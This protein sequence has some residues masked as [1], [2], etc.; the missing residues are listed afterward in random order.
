MSESITC[1]YDVVVV[2]AGNAALTAALAA[3]ETGARVGILEKGTQALRGGNTRFSG[4]LFRFAYRG[5][6]DI[7][8]L[9]PQLSDAAAQ[10]LDV[11][12]YTE[13][14]YFEDVMRV[15]HGEADATLTRVLVHQSLPTVEWMTRHGISWELTSLFNVT[16]GNRRIFNPGSV[17][18]VKGKGLGLSEMLFRAVEA[19]SIPV[20]YQTKFLRLLLDQHGGVRG[21]SVRG[22]QGIY[23]IDCGAVVLA[24]GGFEANP[25]M[26]ARYL[27]GDWDRA[28][29]RGTKYNTG[30]G[31]VAA[32]EI[33]AKPAGH[34]RGCHATPIDAS[35]PA[36]GDLHLTDLTNR[37]SYLYG[38]MVNTHGKRFVD[39]GEELGQYTYAKTG[40]AILSQPGSLA[41]QIFDQK[42]V[43][44]LEKRYETGTPTVANTIEDLATK[45]GLDPLVLSQTVS[46]FNAAVQAGTFNPAIRDGKG[47]RDLDPPKS[48]WAQCLDSPP[49]VA[50]AVTGGITFTFGGL[51]IDTQGQVID[52]EDQPIPGLYAT[53]EI[54]GKF[55][56]HNYPGGTGLMRG[57]VFGKLAGTAAAE[58]A[59][60]SKP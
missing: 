4:A 48:N 10:S 30:E 14:Q 32:L 38:I 49:Y 40:G 20:L 16:L 36:V 12:T 59:C 13:E 22:P 37:L 42:T 55:F 50:Y 54:T 17:L 26:R 58:Y 43:H 46:E 56:Y 33:G 51:E 9:M 3:R 19:Q 34:W 35:A 24:C 8:R 39:E 52:T 60:R 23:D 28:K 44:L 11:G 5:L 2:G 41:Y 29:V 25:E 27:G 31:L 7:R 21:I 57:A 1:H 15:T 45:L 47:T 53:G 6:Q 18:Q